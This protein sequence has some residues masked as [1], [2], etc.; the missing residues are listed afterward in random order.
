[1][2][3]LAQEQQLQLEIIAEQRRLDELT[4]LELKRRAEVSN[5]Y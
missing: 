3:A 1:M 5:Y 4:A 2:L